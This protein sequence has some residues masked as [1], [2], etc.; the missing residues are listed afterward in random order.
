VSKEAQD[1]LLAAAILS[2]LLNPLLFKLLDRAKPWLDVREEAQAAEDAVTVPPDEPA[3]EHADDLAGHVVVVGYGRVGHLLCDELLRRGS[4][5]LV[6]EMESERI[7][8][9]RTRGIRT[10]SGHAARDEALA[11]ANLGTAR[12]LLVTAPDAFEAG[13]IVRVARRLSP[14]LPIYARAGSG[15]AVAHL[16]EQ[17]ANLVVSGEHEMARGMLDSLLAQDAGAVSAT[18]A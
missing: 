15:A 16:R 3:P 18:A 6:M 9:L 8:E 17:G 14:R 10:V 12:A 2:I 5:L 1:V 11:A 13:E 7:E 4:T